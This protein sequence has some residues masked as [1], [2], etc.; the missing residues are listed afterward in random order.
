VLF[1]EEPLVAVAAVEQRLGLAAT[2]VGLDDVL[3]RGARCRPAAVPRLHAEL[4][5]L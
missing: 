5:A 3:R 2:G 4:L 1:R